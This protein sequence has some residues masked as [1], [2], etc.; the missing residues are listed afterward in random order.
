MRRLTP[1]VERISSYTALV[2]ESAIWDPRRDALLWVDIVGRR[3]LRTKPATGQTE[4]WGF[5]EMTGFVQP[6]S[7]GTWLVGQH[8]DILKFEPASGDRSLFAQLE[9]AVSGNRTNDAA[10]DREGRLWLGTMPLPETGL[11]PV[12][13]LYRIE[14]TG[15]VKPMERGLTIPNGIAFSPDGRT[16]Y[17]ADTLVTPH[18]VWKARYDPEMGTPGEK[19]IFAY[20]PEDGGRPDGATVDAAGCYWIAAVRGSQLLRY[21]PDGKLDLAVKVPVPRPSKIAFGGPDLKT[22]FV[23]SISDGLSAEER[24]REPLAGALLALEIGIQGLP[25]VEFAAL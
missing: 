6:A 16:M 18:Q 5:P 22:I 17:W 20:L 9:P 25:A 23:T 21:T 24:A 7:D 15:D 12:G 4:S 3:V 19:E 13:N 2:G 14:G 11:S 1:K 10:C 8:D